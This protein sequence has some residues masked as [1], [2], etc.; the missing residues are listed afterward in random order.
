MRVVEKAKRGRSM[1]T[2]ERTLAND[3]KGYDLEKDQARNRKRWHVAKS[4]PDYTKNEKR[5]KRCW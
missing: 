3:L 4:R 1:N 5:V 2:W